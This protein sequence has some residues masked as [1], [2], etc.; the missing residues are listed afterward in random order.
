[1]RHRL[2]FP[3]IFLVFPGLFENFNCH[4][5]K[6]GV[7]AADSPKVNTSAKAYEVLLN[8]WNKDKIELSEQFKILL[9]NR[10]SRVLGVCEISTGGISSTI[11]DPKLIFVTALK[12]HAS[13][14][15]ICHN[16]PSGNLKPSQE[17]ISLTKKLKEV[18]TFLD[19]PILDH[20]IISQ[21]G[22]YS[23]TDE[24]LL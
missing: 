3:N 24:G 8:A 20:L 6:S 16:H 1:M 10:A 17:D 11:V 15:I 12:V 22:Y 13:S 23:F 4:S 2:T 9:L 19:L 18:V 14:L 7:K 21:D 5:Y